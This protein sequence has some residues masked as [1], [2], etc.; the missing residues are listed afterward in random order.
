V[1]RF[2]VAI[3]AAASL[4]SGCASI[5]TYD[6]AHEINPSKL[7]VS[8][9]VGTTFDNRDRN[10]DKKVDGYKQERVLVPD[11]RLLVR[12]PLNQVVTLTFDPL[13]PAIGGGF[14]AKY[15]TDLSWAPT[16]TFSPTLSYEVFP[17][18]G[19]WT[20]DVPLSVSYKAGDHF[21]FYGGPKYLQQS[22]TLHREKGQV[23]HYFFWGVPDRPDKP[24]RFEGLFAGFAVGWYH[25]QLSPEA[26]YYQ[27]IDD[28]ERVLQLGLQF[29]VALGRNRKKP[30]APDTVPPGLGTLPPPPGAAP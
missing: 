24:L 10:G 28:G 29:R 1:R 15:H 5:H 22:N 27:S 8:A 26:I 14:E 19:V 25:L 17:A 13:P 16:L 3:A 9:T 30:I 20:A 4:S 18:Q 11:A 12:F 21:V 7:A 2:A 23:E 6:A